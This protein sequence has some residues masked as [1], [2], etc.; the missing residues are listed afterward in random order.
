L[1]AT[2]I[3]DDEQFLADLSEDERE[4]RRSAE[5]ILSDTSQ[6]FV[7]DL[8]TKMIIV[9]NQ[10]SGNTLRPYQEPFARRIFESLIIEDN[11][12][13]TALF[14]RQSGKS[15]TVADV[16]ATC[17][18]MFPRLAMIYPELL[19]KYRGGFKVGAFAPTN[20]QAK[21]L[22]NR[23]CERLTSERAQKLFAEPD[24]QE[25]VRER[26]AYVKLLRCGSVARKITAHPR[27]SIEG[28]TFHLILIDECQDANYTVVV[29]S[30]R[31]MGAETGATTVFT[32]TPNRT[33]GIFWRTIQEN[34]RDATKRGHRQ[35]HFQAD[36]KVV[37]RYSARYLKY[38]QGEMRKYGIDSDEFKMSYRCMWL[39]EQGMFTTSEKLDAL[40]DRSMQSLVKTYF[41]TPVVV[42]ID[43]GRKQDKTIVTVVL[44]DW[45]HPDQFGYY[46]HRV[47][48]WLDLESVNWEEQYFRIVEFLRGYR[49]WKVGVDTNGLGDVVVNRLRNLMPDVEFVDLGSSLG[50]QSVRWKHLGELLDR[51][52]ISWPGGAK[53][54]ERRVWKRF[55]Q[56]ME[57][58]EI[59][60]KGPNVVGI[61]PKEKDAH[62]DYPDSLSMACVLS[63]TEEEETV[64]QT[65][66][67]LY[68]RGR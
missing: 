46:N 64:E 17:M 44:V 18:L 37:S 61:A 27:A 38:V 54:K 51:S 24:L 42:G 2:A 7:D 29:K 16:V 58:L 25:R 15:E 5:I 20:D 6:Q 35:N 14:S 49:I 48:N 33:K 43:C 21:I 12:T 47:L 68:V 57:D 65:D 50:E 56:E 41:A 34:K 45:D 4:A 55:R 26:G 60:Y 22:Y 28:E 3:E 19:E 62:D 66:N 23:I 8:V 11:A 52:R 59:E 53:V 13:I 9:C 30:I 40:E 36:W 63:A 10:L 31:P 39:L 1:T 32:G 67:F